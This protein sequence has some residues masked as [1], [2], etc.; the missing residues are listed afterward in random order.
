M[1][2][3]EGEIC[4]GINTAETAVAACRDAPIAGEVKWLELAKLIIKE[5]LSA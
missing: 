5:R 3:S 1:E 4:G 2:D